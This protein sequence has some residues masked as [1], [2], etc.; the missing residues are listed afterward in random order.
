MGRA[1]E[2]IIRELIDRHLRYTASSVAL[3]VLDN[4]EA[5]RDNFVKVFPSEYKRALTEMAAR[6]VEA[7]T[8][9][10]PVAA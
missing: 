7:S 10:T 9:R 2:L 5:C 6:Q 8:E 1:D 3:R 4:W